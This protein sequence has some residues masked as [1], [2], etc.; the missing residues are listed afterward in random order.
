MCVC[1]CDELVEL[2]QS[3]VKKHLKIKQDA[4]IAIVN[5]H[6][7]CIPQYDV[8]HSQRLKDILHSLQRH[9]LT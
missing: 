7:D 8:G 5:A 1:V 4:D 3:T 6:H 2:A 9:V